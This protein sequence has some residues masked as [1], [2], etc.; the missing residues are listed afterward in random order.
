MTCPTLWARRRPGLGA[1][2]PARRA[3][4]H[5]FL[6]LPALF[7]PVSLSPPSFQ[8]DGAVELAVKLYEQSSKELHDQVR[9]VLGRECAW[10]SGRARAG[11]GPRAKEA[12]RAMERGALRSRSVS[13]ALS[14]LSSQVAKQ[15]AFHDRNV[16]HYKAAREAYLKRIE[17]AVDFLKAEG[18]AGAARAAADAVSARVADAKKAGGSAAASIQGA[19]SSAASSA[20]DRVTDA[21]SALV[22]QPT[23]QKVLASTPVAGAVATAKAAAEAAAAALTSSPTYGKAVATGGATLAAVQA[24]GLYQK[25]AARLYPAVAPIADPAVAALTPYLQTAAAALKP[26]PAA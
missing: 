8:V 6:S 5:K 10:K 16:A 4:S 13:P 9:R 22:A 21:W 15:K 23:V 14:N 26:V 25:A 3:A 20:L 11:E 7:F 18:V 1:L 2:R 12:G 17:E 19:A 24:S